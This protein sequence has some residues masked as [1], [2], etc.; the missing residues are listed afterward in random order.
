MMNMPMEPRR[1]DLTDLEL[2]VLNEV[3]AYWGPQNTI[4]E[5]FFTDQDE[6]ALFVLARNGSRPVMVVLTN[7][8]A[9]HHEGML[10]IEDLER[11][12]LVRRMAPWYSSRRE[13]P[14]RR[15]H[16]TCGRVWLMRARA[17]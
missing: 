11:F 5:V 8:G 1:R 14:W 12:V 4:D 9:W 17:V 15:T 7:L 2:F 6:A 3:Q 13:V 16:S 10:T